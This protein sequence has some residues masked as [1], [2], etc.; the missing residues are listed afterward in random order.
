MR[1]ESSTLSQLEDNIEVVDSFV[2]IEESDDVGTLELFVD[3]DFGVEGTLV[4]F[5]LKNFILVDNLDC[6]FGLSLLLNAQIDSGEGSFAKD[7]VLEDDVLP[8]SF[9]LVTHQLS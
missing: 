6:H 3:L 4:V 1:A 5:I 7:I 9:L 2:N 8:Y